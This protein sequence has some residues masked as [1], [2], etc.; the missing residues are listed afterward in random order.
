MLEDNIA[1]INNAAYGRN[2]ITLY[3]NII[4]HNF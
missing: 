2:L 4:H 1:G 3:F